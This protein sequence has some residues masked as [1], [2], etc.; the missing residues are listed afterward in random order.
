VTRK[1]S[2]SHNAISC[3]PC[4]IVRRHRWPTKLATSAAQST[5]N[6]LADV[7]LQVAQQTALITTPPHASTNITHLLCVVHPFSSL[8]RCLLHSL[9]NSSSHFPAEPE[10][11]DLNLKAGMQTASAMQ[12]DA[13]KHGPGACDCVCLIHDQQQSTLKRYECKGQSQNASNSYDHSKCDN[14]IGTGRC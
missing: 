12:H 9:Q 6:Q 14:Q 2:N 3:R 10:T 4:G 11:I 13:I 5:S 8:S 7:A 1:S